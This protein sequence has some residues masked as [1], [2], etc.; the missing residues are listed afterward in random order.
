M[1]TNY[2]WQDLYRS[3]LIELRPE[4][5]RLRIREAEA[6]IQLRFTE[7]DRNDSSYAEELLALSD[8]VRGLRVLA[9]EECLPETRIS[10][11]MLRSEMAS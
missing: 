7:V 8:A 5:L 4:E 2:A 11:E 9:A 1:T 3:A 10:R 6:A